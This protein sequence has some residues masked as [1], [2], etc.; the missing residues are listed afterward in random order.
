MALKI[1]PAYIGQ[2]GYQH[3]VELDRN[4]LESIFGR[5][6]ATR[7]GHFAISPLAG[8]NLRVGSGFAFILGRESSGVE[9]GGYFVYSTGNDDLAWPAAPATKRIDTLLLR[10][11]DDQYGAISGTPEAYYDIVQGVASA[12][13]S[14]RVDADFD[15]GGGFY[16]P[17][18]WWRIA[19]IE[20]D[21][22]DTTINPARIFYKSLYTR[23]G[24]VT[25]CLSTARPSDAVNGDMAY[26]VDTSSF[27][28]YDGTNWRLRM[29]VLGHQI[30]PS[31]VTGIDDTPEVTVAQIE[32]KP[33]WN[34]RTYTFVGTMAVNGSTSGSVWRFKIRKDTALTGTVLRTIDYFHPGGGL[35]NTFT[36]SVAWECGANDADGDFYL[37]AIRDASGAGGTLTV[38]GTES[39][40]K[41]TED[42]FTAEP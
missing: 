24:G 27:I 21:N 2:T 17:G 19:D 40:W 22:G 4:L 20:I 41:M 25:P 30:V 3:P 33:V 16:V 32:N 31:N 35:N 18:A 29:R 37:S 38:F 26:E 9:Q 8:L 23:S 12:T 15:S 7:V 5:T 11:K 13:P 42:Q 6:G 36:F 34:G 39:S 1:K 28:F 10:V 14:A